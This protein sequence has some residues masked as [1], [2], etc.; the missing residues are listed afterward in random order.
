[1]KKIVV[2][3]PDISSNGICKIM[4]DYIKRMGC[5]KNIEILTLYIENDMYFDNDIKIIEIGK[6]RSIIKRIIKETRILKKGNYSLIH[7]NGNYCSRIIECISAKIAKIDRIIL[8]SHNDGVGNNKKI[9]VI[10]H[11]LL[12]KSFDFLAD[13]Y[14]ACS[15]RAAKWM[16]SKKIYT[17]KQY[18]ILNNGIEL[19]KYKFCLKKRKEIRKKLNI[20]SSAFVVGFIGRLSYQKNPMFLVKMFEECN[21]R[22]LDVV[23]MVIGNGE[24]ETKMK[25]KLKELKHNKNFIFVGNVDNAF[26]YYNAM[27]LF[28]LPSKFEGL[29]IVSIEA[30]SNGLKSLFSKNITE[31]C[32]ITDL[33]TFL[34]I[35]MEN[36]VQEWVSK[37]EQENKS[38]NENDRYQYAKIVKNHGYDIDN[39]AKELK[40]IYYGDY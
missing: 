36:S 35:N 27:D 16:F 19:E 10:L 21:K 12:K 29:P 8:H 34:P 17:G 32:K 39:E 9:K 6:T 33:I 22:K 5:N 40:K 11:K 7:I 38:T 15:N 20:S 25:E 23:F 2:F 14:I 18:K 31:E 3:I 30:Q 37:I 24:Y 26:D 28:V 4:A 13:E 1:M